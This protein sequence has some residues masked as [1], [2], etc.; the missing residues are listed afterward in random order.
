MTME[1]LYKEVMDIN[2]MEDDDRKDAAAK[3][4]FDRLNF[5][6]EFNVRSAV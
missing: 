2:M 3:A 6:D 4:F 1:S 5:F